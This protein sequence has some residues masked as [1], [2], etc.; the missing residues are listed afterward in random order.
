MFLKTILDLLTFQISNDN[1]KR[2][3]LDEGLRLQMTNRKMKNEPI[4]NPSSES[5]SDHTTIGGNN[6]I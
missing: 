6:Q 2:V 5:S 4:W 1:G 3:N